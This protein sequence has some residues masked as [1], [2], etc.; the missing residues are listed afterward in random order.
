VRFYQPEVP[1]IAPLRR[2]V[3]VAFDLAL[4]GSATDLI[5]SDILDDPNVK[6]LT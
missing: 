6:N 5:G 1:T 4:E 3:E 2:I